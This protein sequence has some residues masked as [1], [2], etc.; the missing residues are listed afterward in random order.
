MGAKSRVA[1]SAALKSKKLLKEADSNNSNILLARGLSARYC[2]AN[3]PLTTLSVDDIDRDLRHMEAFANA[4]T[5]Y[6]QQLYIYQNSTALEADKKQQSPPMVAMP[7]RIDPEEEK[8][9]ATLR[10]KI[11]KSEAEREVLECEYLSLRAHYVYLVQRLKNHR[12]TVE[13]RLQFLQDLVQKRGKLVAL[14]RARLQ[15]TREVLACLRYRKTGGKLQQGDGANEASSNN[16]DLLQVWQHLEEE[17]KKAEEACQLGKKSKQDLEWQALRVPKIPPG[18]P[19]LLS[20]VAKA[21]G[22]CAAWNAGGAF[23]SKPDSLCWLESE[24]VDPEDDDRYEKPLEV[25]REEV[26]VLKRELD[27]ERSL[28]RDLQSKILKRHKSNME[29][30]AMTALIR[31]ETEAVVARHNI[32]LESD[33]AKE[34]AAKLQSRQEDENAAATGDVGAKEEEAADADPSSGAVLNNTK[35]TTVE[36][37]GEN[38]GDDEGAGEEDEEEGEMAEQG[39]IEDTK[40]SLE[41]GGPD[42]SSPRSKRR[43]L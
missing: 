29:L 18:V 34:A 39:G 5:A 26:A 16:A 30:V 14:Q 12:E 40:R 33:A 24:L 35:T 6:A 38:D 4:C 37:D 7:V 43:K 11:Q 17:C 8:R 19:L 32:L 3:V 23:G 21:P 28:N 41:E 1:S 42:G 9:L 27:K 13:E 25:L 36:E 2:G 15:I 31:T 20:A 10:L 22:F